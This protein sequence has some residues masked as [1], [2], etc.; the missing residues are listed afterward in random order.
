MVRCERERLGKLTL[1]LRSRGSSDRGGQGVDG[2]NPD[3]EEGE[4]G[5][6]EHDDMK[7]R[8]EEGVKMAPGPKFGR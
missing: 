5:F 7:C 6:E 2:E 1:R 4:N 8:E 3:D